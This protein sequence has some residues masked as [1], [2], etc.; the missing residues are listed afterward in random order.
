M[1]QNCG[2]EKTMAEIDPSMSLT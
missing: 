1:K 2:N